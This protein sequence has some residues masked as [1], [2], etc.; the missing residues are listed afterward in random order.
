MIFFAYVFAEMVDDV[1]FDPR[2]GDFESEQFDRWISEFFFG[3]KSPHLT[4]V[5]IDL[6]ALGSISLICV[7]LL[8]FTSILYSY[9]DFRGICYLLIV[10][11]G[12]AIWP[13]VLKNIFQ[14]PRP[15][16]Q[17]HLVNV[18]DLSF[19]SG[20]AFGATAVYIALS[21]YAVRYA[22][23]LRQEIF[24]YSLGTLIIFIV[25]IS[26]IYLGVH[27]PTDVI[28]GVCGG[29]FWALLV[30]GLYRLWEIKKGPFRGP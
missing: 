23:S 29:A 15:D 12:A 14:R 8:V 30:S 18:S 7:L 2:E 10:S 25:G 22:R 3:F 17:Y 24:F 5:M 16:I 20:H 19:P 9:R 26:R 6:T 1:F 28:A 11:L 4:Q 13:L 21:F 27:Y